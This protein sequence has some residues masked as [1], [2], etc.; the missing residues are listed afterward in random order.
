[1]PCVVLPSAPLLLAIVPPLP[2]VVPVPVTCRPP[3]PAAVPVP[4]RMMPLALPPFDEMSWKVT[5]AEPIL[6][7]LMLSAVPLPLLM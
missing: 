7:L 4:L 2:A 3:L 1:M 5:L 6:V